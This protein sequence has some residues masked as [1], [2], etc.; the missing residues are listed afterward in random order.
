MP[1]KTAQVSLSGQR[2]EVK[3]DT[4]SLLVEASYVKTREFFSPAE[5]IV[6]ALGS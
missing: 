5:L 2:A 6:S 3:I 4:R 1:I